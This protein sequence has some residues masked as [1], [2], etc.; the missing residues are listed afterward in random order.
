MG[1]RKLKPANEPRRRRR[2]TEV[3]LTGE[4]REGAKRIKVAP[5]LWIES[6]RKP[7]IVIREFQKAHQ[8]MMEGLKSKMY[9][10]LS[11]PDHGEKMKRKYQNRAG[12]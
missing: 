2:A 8:Q 10:K 9:N 5:G 1:Y 6:K 4:M 12:S 3:K 7:E 11:K